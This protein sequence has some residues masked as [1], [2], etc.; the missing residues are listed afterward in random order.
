MDSGP[1]KQPWCPAL[2]R[3]QAV[4]TGSVEALRERPEP[5][6]PRRT[7]GNGGGSHRSPVRDTG[8]TSSQAVETGDTRPENKNATNRSQAL[9]QHK[10]GHQT[11]RIAFVL[12]LRILVVTAV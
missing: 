4:K 1:G 12:W 5:A 7:N 8:S 11:G 10:E 9:A 6:E 2:A 3:N